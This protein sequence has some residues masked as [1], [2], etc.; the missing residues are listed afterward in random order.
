LNRDKIEEITQVFSITIS[1][2]EI[3][4]EKWPNVFASAK[5]GFKS[6]CSI[7]GLHRKVPIT[8]WLPAYKKSFIIPDIV[9]GVTVALTVI[10]QGIADSALAGLPPEYGLYAGFMGE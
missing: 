6:F 10:P 2:P 8:K 3:F 4:S 5:Q 7:E 1:A 9:A